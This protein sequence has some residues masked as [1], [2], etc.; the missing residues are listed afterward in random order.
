MVPLMTVTAMTCLMKVDIVGAAQLGDCQATPARLQ[1]SS[2][3]S[4]T[5]SLRRMISSA[6]LPKVSATAGEKLMK[7]F[8]HS[9]EYLVLLASSAFCNEAEVADL[10]SGLTTLKSTAVRISPNPRW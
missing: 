3:A 5:H 10:A 8:R 1:A 6:R 7:T 2:T 9:S 4:A